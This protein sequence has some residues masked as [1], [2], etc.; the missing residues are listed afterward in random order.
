MKIFAKIKKFY[1]DHSYEIQT[2][3]TWTAIIGAGWYIGK[4]VN[5]YIFTPKEE[6]SSNVNL[7]DMY[8]IV[9]VPKDDSKYEW[10]EEKYRDTFDKVTEFAKTLPLIDGESYWI[11]K[12]DR[13]NNGEVI[14]S[15]MIDGI[16]VYPKEEEADENAA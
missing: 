7:A 4:K 1:N 12:D 6:E 14:V 9:L 11:D 13:Y 15:H 5:D 10:S 2:V 16:G 8:D 3:L